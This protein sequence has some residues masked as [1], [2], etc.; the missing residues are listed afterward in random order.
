[1]RKIIYSLNILSLCAVFFLLSSCGGNADPDP[2]PEPGTEIVEE[3]HTTD[4][5]YC[6]RPGLA[7]DVLELIYSRFTGKAVPCAEAEVVFVSEKDL[8]DEVIWDAYESGAAV[9][10]VSPTAE[11]L[12][13]ILRKRGIG[14]H[15]IDKVGG[16]LFVAFHKSGKIFSMDDHPAGN[17]NGLVSW[18]KDVNATDTSG[19]DLL[20]A[21]HIS[22]VYDFS[23]KNETIFEDKKGKLQLSG[24]GRFEQY[25]S[26]IPLYAFKSDKSNYVGD[27]Y[28]VDAT[29]SMV[30]DKMYSGLRKDVKWGNK[31]SDVMG[32]YLGDYQIDISLVDSDGNSAPVRFNQMPSP[33]TTIN[34]VTYDSGVSWS[35]NSGLSGGA[36]DSG[37]SL[38]MGCSYSSSK[39]RTVRDL[40]IID[41]SQAE[42]NVNYKLEIKNLPTKYVEPP[43]IARSTFDFHCGWVWCV[44]DTQEFYVSTKYKMKV[45]LTNLRYVAKAENNGHGLIDG[46]S[47]YIGDKEFFFDLPVPNRIPAGNVK[48]VNSE[49]D[50]YM[51]DIVFTDSKDAA[52]T[53]SDLSG[54]VYGTRQFYEVSLP[55]GTY[56]VRFKLGGVA[57]TG[58]NI[59]VK[60]AETLELQ[61]GYYA[62]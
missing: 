45:R 42:G 50:K 21:T 12:V 44:D 54:S 37:L 7:E 11:V 23:L 41:N 13:P 60:R 38:G 48:L 47:W 57:C 55:E 26:V 34:S 4:L 49:K 40:A 28:L 27:F 61:S 35:F 9:V 18:V 31:K 25:Y 62:K 19:E 30:S 17:L 59:V 39:T 58:E 8:D 56:K 15:S 33:T 36:A 32:F 51:T 22:S 46:Y 14:I 52:K 2:V 6:V 43:M 5:D 1:M 3:C 24:E 16:C 29:F 53:F 10:V 20:Q